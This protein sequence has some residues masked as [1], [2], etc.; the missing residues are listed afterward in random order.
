M[1]VR[2]ASQ[3]LYP[4]VQETIAS[5]GL[6]GNDAAA[7]KLAQQ[8]ARVIDSQPG[9]CRGCD[10][11]DCRRAQTSAWA[12]RWLGPLL[13]QALEALG[14]TPAARAAM[15]K[16]KPGTPAGAPAKTKL[17]LLREQRG[18]GRA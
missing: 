1:T 18:R 6:L 8:Y 17:E 14:A 12:A 3:L 15:A 9:H 5:L 2:D 16:S 10:D 13:L 4:A 7:V 11:E